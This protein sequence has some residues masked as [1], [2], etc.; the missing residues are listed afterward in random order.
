MKFTYHVLA[1]YAEVLG[2]R[3]AR[4][5]DHGRAGSLTNPLAQSFTVEHTVDATIHEI[6]GI[7]QKESSYGDRYVIKLSVS[8][9]LSIEMHPKIIQITR[10]TGLLPIRKL[11]GQSNYIE[12]AILRMI[13]ESRQTVRL[14]SIYGPH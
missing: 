2:A 10:S 6:T 11:T 4:L 5:V 14:C 12:T 7:T 1:D 3:D 9:D 8:I 13:S